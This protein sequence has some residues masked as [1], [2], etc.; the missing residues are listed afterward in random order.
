MADGE[1]AE[2]ATNPDG[3]LRYRIEGM[4]CPSCAGK[5]ETAVRRLGGTQ[6]I[7]VSFQTQVLALRIDE[8][9]TSRSAVEDRIRQLG[10]GVTPA[11]ALTVLAGDEPRPE[12]A[13]AVPAWKTWMRDRK[14][15][16]ALV[17]FLLL[18]AGFAVSALAPGLGH[19]GYLPAVLVGL[20][21]FGRKAIALARAGSPFAIE[22]LMS[23]A[24]VG[25]IL[26]GATCEAAA[27]V[28]LFTVG[29]LLEGVAAGRAREG[30]RALE[31]LVPRTALLVEEGAARPLPAASLQVGDVVLIRPG[32]RVPADGMVVEG[33]SEVDESPVTGE[34]MPVPRCEGDEVVG[35]S[36]NTVGALQVRVM[37][38]AKDN[39]IARIIRMVEEA[40][41]AKAPTARFIERFSEVYTPAAVGA[42][43]LAALV[44]PLAFGQPWET[45][46]YRG[47][48]LLLIACP[49]ALV[50]STPAAI[51]SGLAAGA[52]RGLL[53]KGGAA[54]ETIGRVRTAAFDKTGTLTQGKPRVTDVLV[55][56]GTE[57]SVLGLAAAV[58]NG[59][60]HPLACA[61]LERAAAVC[62]PVRPSKGSQV[63]P[64]RAVE[65]LIG[66]K[67]VGVG[68]PV[69]AGE[70]APLPDD[71][72]RIFEGWEGQ[73]KTV[74]VVVVDGTPAGLIAVRD[75]PR[76]DAAAGIQALRELG[77]RP[78]MLSGDN[79]RTAQA[80]GADLG[81]DVAAGL[82]P[83]DKLREIAA[84]KAQGP[85]VMVGDG[86]NDAPSLAA[87]DIGIAMG[88]GTD[89]ALETAD[90]AVLHSRVADI[91]ALV[92]L[93]R[94]TL[95]NIRQNV[96]VALGLKVVFLA[97]TLVGATG[98][99]G[100]VLADTGATVLVTLNALRLLGRRL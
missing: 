71:V 64:G 13:Q 69:Y 81:L 79:R 97:T 76:A 52:R 70:Q 6:D 15:R 51:A 11:G 46:I 7:R 48:A 19:W 31:S 42:A 34:S 65:A 27:V 30:I 77:V 28:F 5:I 43:V 92:R 25:A 3:V 98:L 20:A 89:V 50:L 87:A 74:V 21:F 32:D 58:E 17:I 53:V 33:Q 80:I 83:E 94:A 57:R 29:E 62:I 68:S 96:T 24:A 1:L 88:G 99:P 16:L 63:I 39:I 91:A 84:L 44:P 72:T 47:L 26:I 93:S 38:T 18:V 61:I 22:M 95:T 9:M 23:I 49:C 35:G 36:I 73:G 78:V 4:D 37:R 40:Q 56:T 14:A 82:L 67:R 66:G 54:L 41:E 8:A 90:A 100:A 45:W 86:I 60:N 55:L 2:V 75:E 59:S 12:D 85:V 10:Y